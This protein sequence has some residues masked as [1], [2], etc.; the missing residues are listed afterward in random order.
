MGV[1]KWCD[2][3]SFQVVYHLSRGASYLQYNLTLPPDLVLIPAPAPPL[4]P[5]ATCIF[6]PATPAIVTQYVAIRIVLSQIS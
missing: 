2:M 5:F 4:H 6:G 3:M 1:S